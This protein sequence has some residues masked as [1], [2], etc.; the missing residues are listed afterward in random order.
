MI[1]LINLIKDGLHGLKEIVEQIDPSEAYSDGDAIK[2][3]AQ[4]K[5]NLGAITTRTS[6]YYSNFDDFVKD[7]QKLG[8]H[9]LHVPSNPFNM[10]IYYRK[11]ARRQA[12]ELRDIAEKYDGYF[13]WYAT[14]EDTRK[15]GKLLGY[16]DQAVEEY[17][18]SKDQQKAE[19]YRNRQ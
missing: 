6:P 2:T 11:G 12:E 7:M 17:I 14:E 9:I 19:D 4:G 5:R 8:L 10:Y 16:N 15:I 3:V 18:R 1:K 13:A